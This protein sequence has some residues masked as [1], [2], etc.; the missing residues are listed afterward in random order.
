MSYL[1]PPDLFYGHE[2]AIIRKKDIVGSSRL[3]S[4]IVTVSPES[5]TYID[6]QNFIEAG[7]RILRFKMNLVKREENLKVLAM[8]EEAEKACCDKYG[9]NSWP[10]GVAIDIPN[11]T[12]RTGLLDES[13][14]ENAV[15]LKN[16]D[17]IELTSDSKCWNKCTSKL[18]FMDDHYTFP[19]IK[20]GTEITVRFGHIVLV[21]TEIVSSNLIKCMVKRQGLLRNCE[22]LK[23]RGVK[24]LRPP[25]GK[26]DMDLLHFAVEHKF[27]VIIINGIRYAKTVQ[28]IKNVFVESKGRPPIVVATI[29]D[30][31][32]LD[33]LEDIMKEVDAIVLAREFLA[34]EILNINAMCAIQLKV[35]AECRK[36]GIPYYVSGDILEHTLV[37][38]E[39]ICHEITDITNIV[40]QGGGLMLRTY[41]DP[42]YVLQA[43]KLLNAVCKTT[44]TVS[45]SDFWDLVMAWK[46]PVNAAEAA[47]LGC[48]I[49][50]WQTDAKIIIVLTVSGKSAILLAHLC[51]KVVVM[52]VSADPAT[53]RKL[54]LYRGILPLVYKETPMKHWIDEQ[55][56]R[57]EYATQ[58][59]L[60]HD[61]M[62]YGDNYVVLRK[63]SP[64]SCFADNVS[65]WKVV[66]GES[67]KLFELCDVSS[68]EHV[69]NKKDLMSH[70]HMMA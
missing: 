10:I 30:Q 25:M 44:E 62:I 39:L 13:I 45:K 37:K 58:Y 48:A 40:L 17:I 9:L 68:D 43:I 56:A 46:E 33:N 54:L 24:H 14:Q 61:I 16:R 38:G 2:D 67:K 50:T 6:I 51:P 70:F 15:L 34:Y 36:H 20:V 8:L 22:F 52:T 7:L 66:V 42:N 32:G 29:C 49:S 23:L 11:A 1:V 26:N 64:S 27:D 5:L 28:R 19:S 53:A 47:A 41:S 3:T 4:F 12:C 31:E 35:G 60:K 18:I 59:A 57:I 21:C 63:S 69:K 65:S 55:Y